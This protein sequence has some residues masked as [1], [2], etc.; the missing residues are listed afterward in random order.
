MRRDSQRNSHLSRKKLKGCGVT[1][2]DAGDEKL[3]N[4]VLS[5]LRLPNVAALQSVFSTSKVTEKDGGGDAEGG[6]GLG[7]TAAVAN[8]FCFFHDERL[9]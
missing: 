7:M 8:E 5:R 6:S 9:M 1:S 4:E 2:F 3:I